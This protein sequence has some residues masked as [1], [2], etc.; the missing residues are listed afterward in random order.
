ML[1]GG[2]QQRTSTAS[3]PGQDGVTDGAA[4][5]ES[6]AAGR[7]VATLTIKLAVQIHNTDA[8]SAIIIC[9]SPEIPAYVSTAAWLIKHAL[10]SPVH[11]QQTEK[12]LNYLAFN[13]HIFYF[14]FICHPPMSS[15]SYR[16]PPTK[17]HFS[18]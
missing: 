17:L 5:E 10:T 18:P 12:D 9:R 15:L 1:H 16:C 8:E 11:M 3:E 6:A 14:L 7:V 4:R 13:P 2:W